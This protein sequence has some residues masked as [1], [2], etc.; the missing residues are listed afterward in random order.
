VCSSDLANA[1]PVVRAATDGSIVCFFARSQEIHPRE[2]AVEVCGWGYSFIPSTRA[3]EELAGAIWQGSMGR[4]ATFCV[5]A[6]APLVELD[7]E[8]FVIVSATLP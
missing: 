7:R 2:G 8:M 5:R 4:G 1:R 3:G 6:P